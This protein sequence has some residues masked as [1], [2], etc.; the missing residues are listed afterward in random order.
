MCVASLFFI[1][2]KKGQEKRKKRIGPHNL[3]ILSIIFG[4]MLGDA[5]AQKDPRGFGTAFRFYQSA[6]HAAYLQWLNGLVS[7][8]G[9][10]NPITPQIQARDNGNRFVIRF[11]MFTFA[12]FNWIYDV[13][14]V[15]GVKVVPACIEMYLTPLALAIWIMDDGGAIPGRSIRLATNSFTLQDVEFLAT[16]LRTKYGLD[17]SVH[18]A[19]VPNQWLLYIKRG[20][21]P[22]LASIVK[23]HMHSSMTYK[24]NGFL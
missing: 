12:S 6:A 7:A 16:I 22:K 20:S 9:Y 5:S 2:K 1:N 17:T 4:S 21:L 10:C 3:E 19:G 24:L 8:L 15:N 23:P 13:F 11:S 18:S 14:Y